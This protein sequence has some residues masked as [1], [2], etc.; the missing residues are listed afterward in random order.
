[1]SSAF[2][3]QDYNI[4]LV[5]TWG[6]HIHMCSMSNSVNFLD[7]YKQHISPVNYIEWSPF[8]PDVFLS[9]SSD[10]TMQLWKQGQFTPVLSFTQAQRAVYTIRWSPNRSTVFA[11]I[12]G[13][14][15]EIW[16]LKSS[17]FRPTIVHPAAPG[18]KVTALLFA[19]G[20]DCVLVGDSEGQVTFYQ[21][22]NFSVVEGQEKINN[23]EYIVKAGSKGQEPI[24]YC[25]YK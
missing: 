17:I 9:C 4:Y 25:F 7:T 10:W 2:I 23:N 12:N 8:R 1:M 24:T 20:T 13:Q 22:K 5:G 11:A 6:G 16:D 15:L 19:T 18:V 14:Q 21:L 3:L